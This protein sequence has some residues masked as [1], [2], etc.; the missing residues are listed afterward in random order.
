MCT[1]ID[2]TTARVNAKRRNRVN[3]HLPVAN[4]TKKENDSLE[5]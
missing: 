4:R 1:I 3:F 2:E 5:A